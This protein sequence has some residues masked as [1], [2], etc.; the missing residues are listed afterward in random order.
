MRTDGASSLTLAII[1][2]GMLPILPAFCVIGFLSG[3]VSYRSALSE[4][5]AKLT[6]Q[7]QIMVGSLETEWVQGNYSRVAR[8]LQQRTS[9]DLVAFYSPDCRLTDANPVNVS[10][11]IG[12]CAAAEQAFPGGI[13]TPVADPTGRIGKVF[14]QARLHKFQVFLPIALQI[15]AYLLTLTFAYFVVFSNFLRN[16]LSVK[17]KELM[18][19][20]DSAPIYEE[21]EPIHRILRDYRDSLAQQ[22][23][24]EFKLEYEAGLGRLATQVAHDI[25]SPLAA[26]EMASGEIINL[27]EEKRILIRSAVN[28]IRDIANSLLNKQR[29]S[30]SGRDEPVRGAS[31]EESLEPASPQLLSSLIEALA[32]EKRLQFRSRSNIGIEAWLDASSYGIFAKVQPAEFKRVLSNLIDNAVEA[33]GDQAGAVRV[34][35]TTRDGQALISVRDNGQGIPPG[36]LTKLG[37]RGESHG[38]VGGS[39]LGLYH[40]RTNTESWGGHLEIDSEMGKGTTVTLLIPQT[41]PP[42]WFVSELGLCP[43]KA[44][45]IL[46]DDTS[47]HQVWQGRLDTLPIAEHAVEVVHFSTPHEIRE[48][49]KKNAVKAG[50]AL[51][52]LDYELLGYKETGLDLAAELGIGGNAILV[53]SRYEE[54][55]ILEA[56]RRLRTR[57]IPKGLAGLVPIRITTLVGKRERLDAV[58]ID[59]DPLTRM[60][61]KMAADRAGKKLRAFSTAADFLKESD[62][63]DRRIPVYVD[64]ELG[65]GAKGDVES[66]R[67][68]ALGFGEIYLATG[69][70]SEK[71]AGLTHLRG[72]IGKDPPWKA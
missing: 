15:L 6:Y 37:R 28:R 48:W 24:K 65:D 47:I 72:V 61:W 40:A 30:I 59:D 27:P 17:V 11:R 69:Y 22:K 35:L 10:F 71:F 49:V 14:I 39:G 58:L 25:R 66:L 18:T 4:R 3:I 12:T 45:A 64:A 43:E 32:S 62:A 63:I 5:R 51:Y 36:I 2:R 55:G 7:V 29:K 60:T 9:A 52:L 33:F 42:D 21:F 19:S 13:F 50:S 8:L 56:C 31:D 54:P 57:M 67:I 70:E 41:P 53:T 1:K 20:S 46:D 16:E 26:L 38:K 34:N 44:V 68:H 23:E